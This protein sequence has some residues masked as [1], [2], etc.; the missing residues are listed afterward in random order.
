MNRRERRAFDRLSDKKIEMIKQR[1]LKQLNKQYP[2]MKF[3]KEEMDNA[4]ENLNKK[5][6]IMRLYNGKDNRL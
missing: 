1:T 6:E 5:I 2:D 3:T 4:D